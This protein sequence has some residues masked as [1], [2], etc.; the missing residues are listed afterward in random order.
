MFAGLESYPGEFIP[1]ED[2]FEVYIIEKNESYIPAMLTF[3]NY[4][5]NHNKIYNKLLDKNFSKVIRK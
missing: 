4:R 3:T 2:T 1:N 5:V